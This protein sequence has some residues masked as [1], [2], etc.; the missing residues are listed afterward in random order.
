MIILKKIYGHWN[1][2]IFYIA[3][4]E[5]PIYGNNYSRVTK[6]NLIIKEKKVQK[7]NGRK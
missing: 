1:V 6:T 7:K 3:E 4:I 5:K 2:C